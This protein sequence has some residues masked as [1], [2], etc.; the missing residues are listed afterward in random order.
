M[1]MI[2][3][4]RRCSDE[5]RNRNF[6]VVTMNVPWKK[7]LLGVGFLVYGLFALDWMSLLEMKVAGLKTAVY[8][9]AFVVSPVFVVLGVWFVRGPQRSVLV[10]A[11]LVLL[12]FGFVGPLEYL[13]RMSPWETQTVIFRHGHLKF[14]RVE[15]QVQN[16]GT[17][18]Y[19][20]RTV[21][22]ARLAGLFTIPL[23]YDPL[24]TTAPEWIPVNED[25]NEANWK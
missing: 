14:L 17:F 24:A 16:V 20:N 3:F 21:K 7:V 1:E 5:G 25:I 18:G 13:N 12:L 6:Q 19:R 8:L 11:I 22:V 2:G 4:G 23:R 15:E 10:P 9:G